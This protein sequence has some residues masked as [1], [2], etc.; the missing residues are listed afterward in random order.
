MLQG[1]T[2]QLRLQYAM[3]K[4]V[5]VL[6]GIGF[7]YMNADHM[8]IKRTEQ[9]LRALGLYHDNGKFCRAWSNMSYPNDIKRTFY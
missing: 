1:V 4:D 9:R 3:R 2:R 8:I 6:A 7:F 5:I